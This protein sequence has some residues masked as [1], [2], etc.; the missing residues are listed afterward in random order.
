[1]ENNVKGAMSVYDQDYIP[2][3]VKWGRLTNLVG[4]LLSYLPAISIMIVYK[5]IPPFSAVMAGLIMQASVSGVFWFVEPISYFPVLGIPGTYM[6]FLSGNI[7]N[8]RLPVAVTAQEAANVEPGTEQ[9]SIIST[10]GVG[11]SIVV[12]ILVLTIGVLLGAS[13]LSMLPKGVISTLNNILPA[14]FGA[15]FAQQLVA[16]PKIGVVAAILASGMIVLSKAGILGLLPFG[17][18]YAIII[19]SVFGSIL[20]GRYLYKDLLKDEK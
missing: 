18:T 14:I 13:V 20:I 16:K 15:M 5:F 9:G 17:G 19:V 3:I 1:M 4:I 6:A 7:G 8:L 12:N 2:Y 10:I 11:V